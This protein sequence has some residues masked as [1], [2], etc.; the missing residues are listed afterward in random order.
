MM[1][2]DPISVLATYKTTYAMSVQYIN[3]LIY[4]AQL[5]LH[6]PAV[7]YTEPRF[8]QIRIAEISSSVTSPLHER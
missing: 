7:H 2:Y 5:L 3:K 4:A 6:L 1:E 8:L